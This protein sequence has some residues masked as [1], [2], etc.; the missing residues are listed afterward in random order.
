ML[1]LLVE[2]GLGGAQDLREAAD[3]ARVPRPG[4]DA[5]AV[6]SDAAHDHDDVEH[7]DDAADLGSGRG[8]KERGRRRELRG[9]GPG[10]VRN[11]DELVDLGRVLVEFEE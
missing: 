6:R 5:G 10:A 11:D 8:L 1:L 2:P 3:P 4:A 9:Y 7:L